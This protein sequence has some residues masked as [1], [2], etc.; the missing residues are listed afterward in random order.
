[1]SDINNVA[2]LNNHGRNGTDEAFRHAWQPQNPGVAEKIMKKKSNLPGVIIPFLWQNILWFISG[3]S[4]VTGSVFLVANTEEMFARSLLIASFLFLYALLLI[5]GSYKLLRKRP[6]LISLG[7]I[8][9]SFGMLLIPLSMAASIGLVRIAFPN[10]AETSVAAFLI[11]LNMVFFFPAAKLATGIMERSFQKNHSRLFF[12]I[13]SLQITA[14]FISFYPFW[15]VLAIFHLMLSAFAGFG[16]IG[17]IENLMTSV[18]ENRKKVAL[19]ILGTIIFAGIVSFFHVQFAF[20][21]KLPDGYPGPFLMLLSGLLFY[22]DARFKSKNREYPLMGCITFAI[23]GLSVAAL[24]VTF[25]DPVPHLIN[26]S[27]GIVIYFNAVRSYLSLPSLYLLLGCLGWIY[28]LLVLSFFPFE[29]WFMASAPGLLLLSC[30]HQWAMRRKAQ[31]I[32]LIIFRVMV[33]TGMDLVI[34]SLIGA[35]PGW[36]PMMTCLLFTFLLYYILRFTPAQFVQN[37]GMISVDTISSDTTATDMAAPEKFGDMRNSLWYGMIPTAGIFTIIYAPVINGFSWTEQFSTGLIFLGI[38][39]TLC[40][41][42]LYERKSCE[43]VTRIKILLNFSIIAIVVSLC[44][45]LG[46]SHPARII[47]NNFLPFFLGISAVVFFLQGAVLRQKHAIY[48]AFAL[49]G[50]CGGFVKGQ[51]WPGPS[52]GSFEIVTAFGIWAILWNMKKRYIVRKNLSNDI[53]MKREKPVI[54]INILGIFSSGNSSFIEVLRSPLA[55]AMTALLLSTIGHLCILFFNIPEVSSIKWFISAVCC[56]L[57]LV[58][59]T[60]YFEKAFL[61]IFV[62]IMGMAALPGAFLIADIND[63][64]LVIHGAILCLFFSWEFVRWVRN[65]SFATRIVRIASLAKPDKNTGLFIEMST[66]YAGYAVMMAGTGMVISFWSIAPDLQILP[67]LAAAI[68]FLWF[69]GRIYRLFRYEILTLLVLS[70]LVFHMRIFEITS[71]PALVNDFYTPVFLGAVGFV[72]AIGS[73]FTSKGGMY[74]KSMEKTAAL[75]ALA[76]ILFDIRIM[77]YSTPDFYLFHVAAAAICSIVM[78]IAGYRMKS[79]L[80]NMAGISII[81]YGLL[82]LAYFLLYP[83][84]NFSI[85]PW[86]DLSILW[87]NFSFICLGLFSAANFLDE[88]KF[89]KRKAKTQ[90][91]VFS[92]YAAPMYIVGLL[93]FAWLM[94]K[95]IFLWISAV[96]LSEKIGIHESGIFIISTLAL[97]PLM[98]PLKDRKDWLGPGIL[99]FLTGFAAAILPEFGFTWNIDT[100]IGWAFVLFGT[101]EFIL[102][103]LNSKRFGSK[104]NWKI[105]P[106]VWPWAGL[107]LIFTVMI[108]ILYVR[109]FMYAFPVSLLPHTLLSLIFWPY[110]LAAS[111]YAGLMYYHKRWEAFSWAAIIFSVMSFFGILEYLFA[112]LS[113]YRPDGQWL[114]LAV[115]SLVMASIAHF[116]RI[117]QRHLNPK[118]S[119]EPMRSFYRPMHLLAIAFFT[120][121]FIGLGMNIEYTLPF[122]TDIAAPISLVILA[123]AL[124]PLLRP[125]PGAALIRGLGI[126]I[127]INAAGFCVIALSSLNPFLEICGQIWAYGLLALA[128]FVL[129]P[130]NRRY[131]HW[132]VAPYTWTYMG[133]FLIIGSQL[134]AFWPQAA[135][136]WQYW[137]NIGI[138]LILMMR[139]SSYCWQTWPAAASFTIAGILFLNPLCLEN[140]AFNIK[141]LSFDLAIFTNLMLATTWV[142]RILNK[143]IS[144]FMGW[145]KPDF[146]RPVV[147]FTSLIF[148]I[149]LAKSILYNGFHTIIATF[150]ANSLEF[151]LNRFYI[152]MLDYEWMALLLPLSFCHLFS[153]SRR[154]I[155]AHL[156]LI[157]ILNGI[158]CLLTR[159]DFAYLSLSMSLILCAGFF[160]LFEILSKNQNTKSKKIV[161][162]KKALSAWAY[163]LTWTAS[164]S[165]I[166]TPVFLKEERFLSL[167][168][169]TFVM[170]VSGMRYK[171]FAHLKTARLLFI[172]LLHLWPVLLM[173]PY[174]LVNLLAV[175]ALEMIVLAW[176]MWF[177][178]LRGNQS[179]PFI[180]NLSNSMHFMIVTGFIE[181]VA[182]MY[183]KIVDPFNPMI[184]NWQL[185]KADDLA[186]CTIGALLFLIMGICKIIS[187]QKGTWVYITAIMAAIIVGS[188][189][190]RIFHEISPGYW[191][192]VLLMGCSWILSAV[193]YTDTS[194]S[195]R[196]AITIIA[197]ILPVMAF[198]TIPFE[199]AS[200]HTSAALMATGALYFTLRHATGSSLPLYLGMLMI[201]GSIY[202][203]IPEF[204]RRIGL[205]QLYGIPAAVTVLFLLHMHRREIKKSVLNA[206][207]LA[208]ITSIYM[209]AAADIFI[210]P[211]ISVFMLASGLGL[212]GIFMG[213]G[214]RIRAFLYSGLT[215]LVM[216]VSGHLINF[217]QYQGFDKGVALMTLG[218]VLTAGMFWFTIKRESIIGNLRSV[219]EDLACWE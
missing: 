24:V 82:N 117:R 72:M 110:A 86:Q 99:L 116:I 63:P 176:G 23:Y 16:I 131:P 105:S 102:P 191:D 184:L 210:R 146:I 73:F 88:R 83:F 44:I 29:A 94:I 49:A 145:N 217:Y 65:N 152:N 47:E 67:I 180:G 54:K 182:H 219:R 33:L 204:S 215:F 179:N 151:N 41:L 69:A 172:C 139:S 7:Q 76:G 75:L 192:T 92:V 97:F 140:M 165:M 121:S 193:L 173:P 160:L 1:M 189:R 100:K 207:R 111:A 208:A 109:G 84:E 104:K 211:E 194:D 147:V 36:L 48:L 26:L 98:S 163:I 156:M 143:K 177:L 218:T 133:L 206:T 108:E 113:L 112:Q 126:G 66:F 203:W 158:I 106:V 149:C 28:K 118:K 155:F 95:A 114:N 53:D 174:G 8:L 167:T 9:V 10:I 31:S 89:D 56:S 19:Y 202:L 90:K 186:V 144:S 38:A 32:A 181:W 79:F 157:A 195:I 154:P 209:G 55:A 150:S 87:Y 128:F 162:V 81:V 185:S 199:M 93:S 137:L 166:L 59:M 120:W 6:E 20:K 123:I 169:L 129:I 138:Y 148:T 213:I 21:A 96:C 190:L 159:A 17:L 13:A 91:F 197:G 134:T 52:A 43:A 74:R 68:S 107:G 136:K 183:V 170:A 122:K 187:T 27:L 78:L 196:R 205:F 198:F 135:F 12:T 124:F 142:W 4:F 153:A 35:F 51:Y 3:F 46:T 18:Y 45:C 80:L 168:L 40:G 71:L 60:G 11:L 214:M 103:F 22:A 201:N 141:L 188:L 175:F 62:L 127:L 216:N 101:G 171:K 212:M 70:A 119:A 57:L 77:L 25:N 2:S 42:F 132:A 200:T 30:L 115:I 37:M 125:C 15:Q 164:A 161:P 14:L 50:A 178:R 5:F 34:W 130:F 61:W 64:F 39:W 58:L 85:M